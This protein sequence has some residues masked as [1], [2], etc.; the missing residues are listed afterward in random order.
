[1]DCDYQLVLAC[2]AGGF[3]ILGAI[4]G[5]AIS[6][7]LTRRSANSDR[8]TQIFNH[9]A[10]E[11][12]IQINKSITKI[13]QRIPAWQVACE[14]FSC[15]RDARIAFWQVLSVDERARFDKDWERGGP[16]K[17]DSELRWIATY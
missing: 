14:D 3:T 17:L 10:S 1:M 9:A 5:A 2:I 4:I 15:I 11:F 13:E 6:G 7:C 8:Q 12:R 16:Q